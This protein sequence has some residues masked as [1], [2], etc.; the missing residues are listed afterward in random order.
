M[1]NK[2]KNYINFYAPEKI[3][4][5]GRDLYKNDAVEY[6]HY[7]YK[8]KLHYFKVQGTK[9][10]TVKLS[11]P[12]RGNI[13]SSCTC[14]FTWGEICKHTVAALHYASDHLISNNEV[15]L[16]PKKSSNKVV[17]RK[18]NEPVIIENFQNFQKNDLVKF[19][20][21]GKFKIVLHD[22]FD[23][24]NFTYDKNIL[25][26]EVRHNKYWGNDY[27]HVSCIFTDG[28]LKLYSNQ[29]VNA[30]KNELKSSEWFV[31]LL[32]FEHKDQLLKL[33]N[34][35]KVLEVKALI[36][37]QYGLPAKHFDKYFKF[38]FDKKRGLIAY[39]LKAAEGL[40]SIKGQHELDSFIKKLSQLNDTPAL[41]VKTK[42]KKDRLLGFSINVREDLENNEVFYGAIAAK[43]NK[44]KTKLISRFNE[45]DPEFDVDV[46][47]F[48]EQKKIVDWIFQYQDIEWIDEE[49]LSESFL[50]SQKIFRAIAQQDFVFYNKKHYFQ[51]RKSNLS[52]VKLSSEFAQTA[53][54]VKQNRQFVSLQ[55]FLKIGNDL[56]DVSKIDKTRSDYKV[57]CY[58]DIFYHLQNIKDTYLIVNYS[59]PL[60]IAKA[61]K[62]VLYEKV[63]EPLAKNFEIEFED[64]T[65]DYESVIMDY[66]KK[67]IFLS[68]DDDYIIIKLQV[69]YDHHMEVLLTTEG[70]Y[71]QRDAQTGKIMKYVRNRELENDF[72]DEIGSLHPDFDEQKD[73]RFFYIHFEDF[74]KDMWFYQFFD[75]LSKHQIEV[76]GVKELKK[77]K[78]SPYKAK[79]ATS[80]SS[81][82]DWFDVNIDISFGQNH[83][84]LKDIKR[85]IVNK[86]KYIQL[87]D[88]SVGILPDE[89]LHKL[90][91]YF[92]NASNV[93]KDTLQ[94]SKMR[95]SIVDE[96]FEQQDQLEILDEINAKKQRLKSFKEIKNVAVPKE[97]TAQLRP[98]QKEGLNWL[99]F[100]NEMQWGGILA[101]DM[102]LGKTL[103][104]LT[105]LQDVVKKDATPN[106][107]VVPTTLLFNWQKEIEKFAPK[108]KAYY[109]YGV[110]RQQNT[111]KFNHYDLIFTTY[112]TLLRDIEWLHKFQFNYAILDESQAIKNPSSRRFKAVSLLQTK[113][114]IAM[115]G[116]PIENS[117]FDLYAQM[118]FVNP[119]FF[120]N[121]KNFKDNYSDPIDKDGDELVAKEL[122]KLIN[123]FILRRTKEQVATELPPKVEDVIYCEMLPAQ[124]K[125]YEAYR[126]QYRDK[127]LKQIEKEGLAKSKFMVL[128]A[129]TRL[130]QICD[131]PLLLNDES[132]AVKDSIKIQEIITH[133]TDK[134]AQHKVLIFSQFT[135]M[136][137]LLKNELDLLGIPYEYLD[138]K[139]STKKRQASVQNFQD[140]DDL[141]VFLISLKAGGTGLNLTAADYVYILDPWWN[142]A[143]ENQAIDRIYRIGQNKKVFAY[144]MICKDTVEEK[145]LNL[146]AK[147]KKIATDIIQTDDKIMKSIKIDDIKDLLG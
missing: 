32:L 41:P 28:N 15:L 89:W 66:Q 137:A 39:K 40:L 30:R 68:E 25:T 91:K 9:L 141:R 61:H 63:I 102:G 34:P 17:Y 85:A 96:L 37:A 135:S 3:R 121:I 52:P 84:Q 95:F 114:R 120:I 112:G 130:R 55:A 132:I 6:S 53:L 87:H 1:I 2:I 131:S 111:D 71:V 78:Y 62:D 124:R 21:N 109:H 138:G 35:E 75:Y 119:G 60:K 31:L 133:I 33:L 107:I 145:I 18:T 42:H 104:I 76:Y 82:Q 24:E 4:Q 110:D 38:D 134:T 57:V 11:L 144:R 46:Q 146:Q 143:V 8:N 69:V 103:Q 81:G 88:G 83:V 100:L 74:V 16:K 115:T 90:E 139:S 108:L 43:P 14:P 22:D 10:Y 73:Q 140:N 122:Q 92:R 23:V 70:N 19:S 99:H 7:D 125:V 54:V 13:N 118:S 48:P 20:K 98:Y 127:L 49:N 86:Q 101:D 97:I 147:K 117:T 44:N 77:F 105:F 80:V 79:V 136:L 26:F 56:I 27:Y 5:R 45:Y 58:N 123:P 128:E 142:P 116:T 51:L 94:I 12:D 129:L 65:F 126:N 67:Q 59:S 47:V 64:E 72:V 106:L 93:D 113:N 36:T 50:L 29:R